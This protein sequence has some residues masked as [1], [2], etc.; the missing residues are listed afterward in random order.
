MSKERPKQDCL[1]VAPN[2]E[3]FTK[4]LSKTQAHLEVGAL[5]Q[6]FLDL[7][8]HHNKKPNMTDFPSEI[9]L[10]WANEIYFKGVLSGFKQIG[11][12]R[13]NLHYTCTLS[14]LTIFSKPP[15]KNKDTAWQFLKNTLKE[16]GSNLNISTTNTSLETL[17]DKDPI[18]AELRDPTLT[19]WQWL[20]LLSLYYNF[21]FCVT[22]KGKSELV[23]FEPKISGSVYKFTPADQSGEFE[24]DATP[25][26]LKNPTQ[27]TLL[28]SLML[29]QFIGRSEPF[30]IN[31][32]HDKLS[33]KL[34]AQKM[35]FATIR[36]PIFRPG[37][38]LTQA[39]EITNPEQPPV[40]SGPFF[41]HKLTITAQGHVPIA[42]AEGT[43]L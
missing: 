23:L 22:Y 28:E 7:V 37:L 30:K 34:S 32:K 17:L 10:H 27:H 35:H 11:F 38:H 26:L 42:R 31:E 29:H 5:N 25:L 4:N 33:G 36:L 9:T 6:C 12:S 39:F 41:L 15:I 19:G 3:L 16:S 1:S 2:C 43:Y 20:K 18:P 8:Y 40:I 21:G 14:R 13:V 24:I